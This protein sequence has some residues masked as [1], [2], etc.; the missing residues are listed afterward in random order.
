MT[1]ESFE[2]YFEGARLE[3]DMAVALNPDSVTRR[4]AHLLPHHPHLPYVVRMIDGALYPLNR[5]YMP[6][7]LVRSSVNGAL[8]KKS[9]TGG[10]AADSEL[11]AQIMRR[12]SAVAVDGPSDKEWYLFDDGCNPFNG[13]MY[14]M[15][16]YAQRLE[17]IVHGCR[18]TDQ[19]DPQKGKA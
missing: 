11:A 1:T 10:V 4:R 9:L 6:L 3:V 7:G 13:N 19:N 12:L 5:A 18:L 17:N 16:H 15:L 2:L 8:D 14:D